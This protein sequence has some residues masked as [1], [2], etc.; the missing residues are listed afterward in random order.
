MSSRYNALYGLDNDE[1]V[2]EVGQERELNDNHVR[3]VKE[4]AHNKGKQWVPRERKS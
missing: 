3:N 1:Q 2:E 4:K